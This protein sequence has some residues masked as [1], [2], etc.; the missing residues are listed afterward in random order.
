MRQHGYIPEDEFMSMSL[1]HYKSY[2]E[3]LKYK[4]PDHAQEYKLQSF[5]D[6]TIKAKKKHGKYGMRYVVENIADFMTVEDLMTIRDVN[7]E[8]REEK[9][10]LDKMTQERF[11]MSYE[12]YMTL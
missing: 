4:T 12:E 9:E 3:A 2:F 7:K 6:R 8:K 5:I 11:G 10:R 1:A